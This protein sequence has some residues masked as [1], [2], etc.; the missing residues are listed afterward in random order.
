MEDVAD[1][2]DRIFV[3]ND[4]KLMFDGAPVEVF[5]HYDELTSMGLSVPS[6]KRVLHKLNEMGIPVKTDAINISDAVDEIYRV[7]LQNGSKLAGGQR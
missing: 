3:I 7:Y 2:A 5:N 4:G 6:P 1:Y